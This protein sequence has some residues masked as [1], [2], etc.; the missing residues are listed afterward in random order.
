LGN[1]SRRIGQVPL[2]VGGCGEGPDLLET[3][4]NAGTQLSPPMPL[5]SRASIS[6]PSMSTWPG[7]KFSGASPTG[8]CARTNAKTVVFAIFYCLLPFIHAPSVH[9]S[10][11]AHPP[12]P[13]WA[14]AGGGGCGRGT[15]AE[16]RGS[17]L[18]CQRANAASGTTGNR[19]K[20]TGL[21]SHHCPVS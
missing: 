2:T 12:P 11:T 1:S 8:E 10:P 20:R 18:N 21:I 4:T 15:H 3:W 14:S 13:S 16:G 17:R 19:L 9:F 6:L 7:L 5:R